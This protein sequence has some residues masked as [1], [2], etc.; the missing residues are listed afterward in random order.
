MF[1][2]DWWWKNWNYCNIFLFIQSSNPFNI[3]SKS[4]FSYARFLVNNLVVS[5]IIKINLPEKEQNLL[6][7]REPFDLLLYLCML[8]IILLH[9][10]LNRFS[11]KLKEPNNGS[12]VKEHLDEG[13]PKGKDLHFK[14]EIIFDINIKFLKYAISQT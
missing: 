1:L 2:F 8:F 9:D 3:V 7:F 11:L 12:T 13:V 6:D 14:K 10:A 4:L 5:D